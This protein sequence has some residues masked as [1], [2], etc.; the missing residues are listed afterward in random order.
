VINAIRK[1]FVLSFLFTAVAVYAQVA[2]SVTGGQSS[3]WAGGEF[4]N[5]DPDYGSARLNGLGAII[6]ANLT[7]K[8]GVVG[9]ARWLRWNNTNDGGELQSDYL[10]GAKYRLWRFR[11]F[12]FDAKFL[13]GGVWIT[14]PYG[15]GNGSYFAYAPG[16]NVDYRLSRKFLIRGSY[17]YQ[18]LPSAPNIPGE[19]NNGLTPNGFT[20]GVEY[21][22]LR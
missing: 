19:P 15:V 14:F 20:V 4:S 18:I 1:I 8:L 17:E 10:V 6:D 3:L 2:P 11:G 5:F 12:D 9:E 22:I 21:Q 16:A 13:A 7:H